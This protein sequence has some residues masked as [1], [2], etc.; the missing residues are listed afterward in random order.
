MKALLAA[1][2][3]SLAALVGATVAAPAIP[4]YHVCIRNYSTTLP[5]STVL[6]ALPAIQAAA[7]EDFLPVWGAKAKLEFIG[8]SAVPKGC[9]VVTIRDDLP[10]LYCA[11]YHEVWRGLPRAWAL[12]DPDWTVIVTHELWE[13]LADPWIQNDGNAGRFIKV[14]PD[15]YLVEVADPVEADEFAYTRAG[16]DGSP[17]A[18]SDFVTPAWYVRKSRGPYDFIGAVSRP[19]ELLVDGYVSYMD[20]SGNWHQLFGHPTGR[21]IP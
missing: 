6:N 15:Y 14:G 20:S 17:V 5:D 12:S 8:R 18:I 7:D 9:W 2:A 1:L 10:C 4:A 21:V 11:G 16:A 19:F 3:A 13:M